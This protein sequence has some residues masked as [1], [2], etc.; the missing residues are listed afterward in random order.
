MLAEIEERHSQA[1]CERGGRGGYEH[2]AAV[3][4]GGDARRAMNVRAHVALVGQEGVPVCRPIA[5]LH[6][7]RAQSLNDRTGRLECAGGGGKG[8]E[9]GIALGVHLG[10]TLLGARLAD[11]PPVLG[12]RRRI[13]LGAELVEE[14]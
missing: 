3:A 14:L 11:D 10:A 9:E 7:A 2:L 5:D 8:E 13:A 1:R 12:E 6:S 4:G